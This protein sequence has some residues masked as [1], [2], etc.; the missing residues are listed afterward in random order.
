MAAFTLASAGA[1]AQPSPVAGAVGDVLVAP[2]V[3]HFGGVTVWSERVAGDRPSRDRYFLTALVDG[4][5]RRLPVEARAGVP[6]DVDL[7]PGENGK[8]VAVYSRC[9]TEP[10]PVTVRNRFGSRVFTG[11]YPAWTAGRGCDLFRFDFEAGNERLI[12]GAS[13]AQASEMLPSVWRGRIAFAR[14][15]ERRAGTRGTYPYLYTRPLGASSGASDRQPGGSRGANGL[16]G[17]VNLDLY[18]RRLSFVWNYSTAK[19]ASGQVAGTTELRIST[20]N[21]SRERLGHAAFRAPS[22]ASYLSPTGSR[23]RIVYGFQRIRNAGERLPT[24]VTSLI[25]RYRLTNA[26]RTNNSAPGDLLVSLAVDDRTGAYGISNG[27]WGTSG[28][29]GVLTEAF[30]RYGN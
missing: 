16:P 22:E 11:P 20:V 26:E 1:S 27:A 24:S 10:D 6:F 28:S 30:F 13:T 14:V 21:G 18:G 19:P 15:Y 8:P 7:G 17:P 9:R 5:R 3:D 25:G 12:R 2:Y 23:G 29:S 4:Q